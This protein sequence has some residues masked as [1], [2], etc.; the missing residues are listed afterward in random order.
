M[1]NYYSSSSAA[2]LLLRLFNSQLHFETGGEF[3]N[4]LPCLERGEAA[5]SAD[6][7]YTELFSTLLTQH[8]HLFL[9]QHMIPRVLLNRHSQSYPGE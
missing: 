9:Q 1:E 2:G 4:Q 5:S 7:I 3:T 6:V 8:S